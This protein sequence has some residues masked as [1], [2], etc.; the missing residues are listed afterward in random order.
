MQNNAPKNRIRTALL[1][2]GALFL[3]L[4]RINTEDNV[5]FVLSPWIWQTCFL[6]YSR[7]I[8]KKRE[9]LLFGFVFLT[10]V[11]IRYLHFLGDS[12]AYY[13][14]V[15]ILLLIVLA[16]AMFLPFLLDRV[17]LMYSRGPFV[18]LAFP[19][20]RIAIE[21][22]IIGQ[23]F[24]LALS[25]F[26]NKW[27]IQSV[28]VLGDV[29]IT[30]MVAFVPSVLIWVLLHRDD[31]KIIRTGRIVLAACALVF[32]LGGIRYHTAP[33]P[34]DP[35][36]M[37]YASGPQKTYYEDPSEEDP[38]YNENAA[39]LRKTASEAAANGARLMAYAEE[40]FM[41]TGDERDRLL[42]EAMDLAKEN[43]LFILICLDTEDEDGNYKNEAVFIDSEGQQ[44][45]EYA[46]T[47][48][49]PVIEDEYV[50]GDGVI[51]SNYV[52]I[53]GVDRVI[54]YTVCYDATFSKYLLTMDEKTDLFINPSWDWDEID[55]LNYRMQGIS[56]IAGG[57]VLFKPT[58]DGWSIVSD[59]FGRVT[60][61]E[62][63]LRMDYD[64][65]YYT[66]VPG[67]RADTLYAEIYKI[68]T[69][70]WTI[71][72]VVILAEALRILI[73]RIRARRTRKASAASSTQDP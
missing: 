40:A 37:A 4:P 64:Q 51:P 19:A 31:R 67:A 18:L 57:V 48:L 11:E 13:N 42:N 49:I 41:V 2:A 33:D 54:S 50:A 24:N 47:N 43:D 71:F 73:T 39:Y 36:L 35:V 28:A 9:W 14:I 34:H 60:Y 61:K 62:N 25:Q 58:V 21:R 53:D 70:L 44:L 56:A 1:L 16:L 46:K 26:G 17:F 59:P 3:I 23:Q 20:M 68:L 22:F 72:V 10:A 63:T 45:S 65:V 8:R 5:L 29:F 15:S 52:T 69:P 12:E 32:V 66:S 30:F 38:D 27:L 55:D 6:F 7:T